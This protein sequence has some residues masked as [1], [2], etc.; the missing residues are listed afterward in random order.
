MDSFIWKFFNKAKGTISVFLVIILVPIMA[1]CSLFVD[2]S[3]IKL[4]QAV[5]ASAADSSL[6]AVLAE[7]DS[8]LA[9]LYGLMAS[10]Q[11]DAE[12]IAAAK[13]YF[14]DSL[15]SQGLSDSKVEQYSESLAGVVGGDSINDFL[16]ILAEDTLSIKAAN[17][18]RLTNT[19][20]FKDQIV[21]FMKY[22]APIEAV[23]DL[24]EKFKKMK[25]EA[26]TADEETKMIEEMEDYYNAENEVLKKCKEIYSLIKEYN[27]AVPSKEYIEECVKYISQLESKYKEIH[28][29]VY[30]D[31]ANTNGLTAFSYNTSFVAKKKIIKPTTYTKNS[32]KT[33][34]NKMA[35][36]VYSFQYYDAK[37]KEATNNLPSESN[38]YGVQYWAQ[39]SK[40]IT[41]NDIKSRY[42]T[43]AKNI[44]Y[45]YD[46]AVKIRKDPSLVEE[47]DIE[48]YFLKDNNNKY[49]YGR[50]TVINHVKTLESKL[51]DLRDYINK[52]GNR[53]NQSKKHQ[54]RRK[55]CKSQR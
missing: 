22:R 16:G 14:K 39:V 3:R 26:D 13:Q 44:D 19:A 40:R 32:F 43:W 10:C 52:N 45:Y 50:D 41:R 48:Q 27:Q 5:I 15:V 7:F 2:A 12:V 30:K 46:I 51:K 35:N 42:E 11:S 55:R 31:L 54:I 28:K 9:E 24:I 49:N 20:I 8:E 33:E 38:A 34:L 29:V 23:S 17:N 53:Y 4:S 1:M 18:G 21:E 36:A 25:K 47:C 37:F 6:N